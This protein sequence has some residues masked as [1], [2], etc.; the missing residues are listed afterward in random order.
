[1]RIIGTFLL[2]LDTAALAFPLLREY[3]LRSDGYNEPPSVQSK[4]QR[5][6]HNKIW[7][8]A[9]DW[10]VSAIVRTLSYSMWK[11]HASFDKMVG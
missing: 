3:D 10:R 1:L 4:L 8:N 6:A 2:A 5:S 9:S 7:L 11:L